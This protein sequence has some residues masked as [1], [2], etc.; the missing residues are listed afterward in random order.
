MAAAG[1]LSSWPVAPALDWLVTEG[2]LRGDLRRVVQDL[3]ERLVTLGAPLWRLYLGL[4]TMHPQMQ[5]M[6]L[7]W[8]RGDEAAW[9]PRRFGIQYTGAYL[10]SPIHVV[11]QTMRPTRYRL[12]ELTAEH[13]SVLHEVRALGGTDY[14]ALPVPFAH[15][16]MPILTLATDRSDGFLP[17]DL[18]AFELLAKYLAPVVE[19][20]T[21]RR[22]SLDLLETYMGG[23]T[24]Q[25]ILDGLIRR[26]DGDVIRA[27][28]WV[29]D[30]RN[31]TAI[32]EV[33]EPDRV[34]DML[35]QYFE[36]VGGALKANGG[37][38][39]K[40]M[41]DGVLAIFPAPDAMFLPGACAGAADAARQALDCLDALNGRRQKAGHPAIHF[42][43]G[44][45]VGDVTYGNIGTEDRLD[46]TVI[47]PAVNRC[48]RLQALTKEAGVPVLAS[49]EFNLNCPR[50]LRPLGRLVLRGVEEPQ[51]V[52]TL[53]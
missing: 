15:G 12:T 13:H 39:L 30:L 46:F 9:M 25:R 38:I 20:E 50:K 48:S 8:Q 43:I 1:A 4:Q 45:H 7:T 33:L 18:E 26:G 21:Q 36:V 11:R 34:L 37:E 19:A 28:L 52:F 41:G 27:V 3:A 23:H 49:A 29:S 51:E 16:T 24:A 35:N 14:L 2:R 40:F 10:G 22:I 42:G 53:P 17:H 47:G 31:F 32:S 44:L 5:A 6:A